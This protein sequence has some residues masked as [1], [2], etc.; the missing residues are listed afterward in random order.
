MHARRVV[1]DEERLAGLLALSMKP[2]AV[3]DEHLVEGLHVVLGALWACLPRLDGRP[4]CP[5]TAPAGPR[6]R[7][8]VCRSCPSAASP[9]GRRCRSP[10]ICTRLRGPY[11]VMEVPGSLGN[12]YQYGIRHGV[13]VVQVAEELVEAVQRRQELVQVAE[14]V[15]AELPGGVA[16]RLERGRDGACLG[17]HADVGA[18]LAEPSSEPVRSGISP[19]MKAGP[20]CR[21]ASP[22]RSSQ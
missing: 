1:P 13:E 5:C 9:V 17:R 21:A 8:A 10:R 18:G 2:L 22:R 20:A 3:L 6:R 12:E 7:S 19:V 11:L 15:L 16:L 14:V 4:S